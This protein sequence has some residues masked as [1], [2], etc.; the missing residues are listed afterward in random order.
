MDL[1]SLPQLYHQAFTRGQTIFAG[2][3]LRFSVIRAG[4]LH[5]PSGHIVVCDPLVG[6]ER[7]PFVQA[8]LPGR[9]AVDLSMGRDEAVDVE[10]I[11]F[12][13]ILFTKNMPVVWVKAFRINEVS[14]PAED[15]GSFGFVATSATAAFMDLETAALF[16][17]KTVDEVDRLLDALIVNY[18]PERNWLNY[19]VDDGH[20][21]ILFSA[22]R[23]GARFPSYFAIDD[24]GDVCLALTKLFI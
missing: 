13:R 4:T 17:L 11:V 8:V 7:E 24:G 3:K 12:A 14:P 22:S 19:P 6:H 20:N 1:N 18:R 9:Y 16:Q 21:V 23:N 15:G 2:R 10:R 5:L